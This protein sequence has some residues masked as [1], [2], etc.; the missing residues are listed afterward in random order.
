LICLINSGDGFGADSGG[1]G[2]ALLSTLVGAF[3]GFCAGTIAF[4]NSCA[5]AFFSSYA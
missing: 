4:F 2:G 1:G 3:D 5:G